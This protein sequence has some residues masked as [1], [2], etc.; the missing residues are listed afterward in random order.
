MKPGHLDAQRV[1]ADLDRPISDA[2]GLPAVAYTDPDILALEHQRLFAAG[3]V[4][5]ASAQQLPNPGDVRPVRVAGRA[6]LV[7]RDRDGQIRVFH[8]VCRHRGTKLV[9]E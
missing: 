8:N 2:Y 3:C 5:V 1:R 9:S 4:S 6:L 7:V